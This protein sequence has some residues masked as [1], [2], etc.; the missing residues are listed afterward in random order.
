MSADA[1]RWPALMTAPTAADYL[2]T[3]TTT[4]RRLVQEGEIHPVLMRGATKYARKDLDSYVDRLR[5]SA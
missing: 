4:L 3:S 5:R 2:D 1:E